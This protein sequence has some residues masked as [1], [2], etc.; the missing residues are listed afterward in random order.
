MPLKV[1]PNLAKHDDI[2]AALLKLHEGLS[3]GDSARMNFR[4]ILILM[5]HIGDEG[6][7]REAIAVAA[8]TSS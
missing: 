2:Y 4:L 1:E 5:N 3:V 6:T 7:I 8:R